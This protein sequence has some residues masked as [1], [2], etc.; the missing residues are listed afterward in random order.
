MIPQTGCSNYRQVIM[1][2]YPRRQAPALSPD[3]LFVARF[4][5]VGAMLEIRCLRT[6]QLM[7]T[8]IASTVQT[9]PE[10]Y[11]AAMQ[12][13]GNHLVLR[14]SAAVSDV[15]CLSECIVMMQLT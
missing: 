8:L 6:G 12:W 7:L 13:S 4:E 1:H 9:R 2:G 3:G 11:D 5:P 10:L 15:R 14:V